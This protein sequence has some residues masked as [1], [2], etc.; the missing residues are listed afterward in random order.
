[1]VILIA[2]ADLLLLP[3]RTGVYSSANMA[4]TVL[5][6][7][8]DLFSSGSAPHLSLAAATVLAGKTGCGDL[9]WQRNSHHAKKAGRKWEYVDCNDL[10]PA[11]GNTKHLPAVPPNVLLVQSTAAITNQRKLIP[12]LTS[13]LARVT[14]ILVGYHAGQPAV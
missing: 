2:A 5:S 11:Q 4:R 10:P 8:V 7:S 6:T 12:D 13:V 9:P 1:M 3:P 14:G